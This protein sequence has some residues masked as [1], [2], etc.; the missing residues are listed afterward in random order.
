MKYALFFD[1]S[2]REILFNFMEKVKNEIV[3]MHFIGNDPTGT[4]FFHL[5]ISEKR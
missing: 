5:D 1:D 2:H 4:F 3:A